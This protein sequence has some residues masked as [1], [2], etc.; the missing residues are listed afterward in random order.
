MEGVAGE[1]INGTQGFGENS[2]KSGFSR[3]NGLS[4]SPDVSLWQKYTQKEMTT[5]LSRKTY[6]T[7]ASLVTC[8]WMLSVLLASH[9]S[10]HSIATCVH[11]CQPTFF[12]LISARD[13]LFC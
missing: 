1:V 8:H 11:R 2:P 12:S 9:H 13:R 4:H 6:T 3:K 7:H 10:Q 5:P